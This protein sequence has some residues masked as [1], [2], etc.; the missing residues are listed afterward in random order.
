M[1]FKL[2]F[3]VITSLG[4]LR[5]NC[6]EQNV[7]QQLDEYRSQPETLN[8]TEVCAVYNSAVEI[9]QNQIASLKKQ[10]CKITD[11]P[12]LNEEETETTDELSTESIRSNIRLLEERLYDLSSDGE[13]GKK[14]K[15]CD[16]CKSV[17]VKAFSE[18]QQ[19]GQQD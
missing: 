1:K 5:C 16:C 7:F 12:F 9:V 2:L 3:S 19:E 10:L 15:Q 4:V 18:L 17:E 13:L 11:E 8:A 6:M 14:I